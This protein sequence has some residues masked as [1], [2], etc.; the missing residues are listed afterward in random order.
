M[1]SSTQFFEESRLKFRKSPPAAQRINREKILWVADLVWTF[2]VV[3]RPPWSD[4]LGLGILRRF[5]K[6]KK[7]AKKQE[8][9]TSNR[10]GLKSIRVFDI[11]C[12]QSV[13]IGSPISLLAFPFMVLFCPSFHSIMRADQMRC[14][15]QWRFYGS[16]SSRLVWKFLWTWFS[17][18][19]FFSS[20]LEMMGSC[21]E[22][23]L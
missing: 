21:L 14:G 1:L 19:G 6:R 16:S 17:S 5:Q 8:I 4:K 11:Y 12:F 23:N 15:R 10:R 13:S 18:S 2:L 9:S 20:K 22:H 3:I 7:K